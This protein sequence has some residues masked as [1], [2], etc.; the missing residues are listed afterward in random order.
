MGA[1]SI[2]QTF[3][4]DKDPSRMET[5]V[6]WSKCAGVAESLAPTWC[7]Y[8]HSFNSNTNSTT[9]STSLSEHQSFQNKPMSSTGRQWFR[10]IHQRV[11][12]SN[13]VRILFQGLSHFHHVYHMH[14]SNATEP[15]NRNCKSRHS[16][17]V[18]D[19]LIRFF[20]TKPKPIISQ[21]SILNHT[22]LWMFSITLPLLFHLDSS[23][24]LFMLEKHIN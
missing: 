19:A 5:S 11:S 9:K 15:K 1:V 20:Y 2:V 3:W 4:H 24:Y 16:H 14:T 18:P 13:H 10:C 6:A 8:K 17:A 23:M 7:A 22:H 21:F 12:H